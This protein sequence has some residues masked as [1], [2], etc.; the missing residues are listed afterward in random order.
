MFR[1]CSELEIYQALEK[2]EMD[3]DGAMRRLSNQGSFTH[4]R[5][6]LFL[7][8]ET[9]LWVF[10]IDSCEQRERDMGKRKKKKR[11]MAEVLMEPME[12]VEKF[13]IAPSN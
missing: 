7:L 9:S 3:F 6:S 8:L 10:L 13:L 2:C 5:H 4:F 11:E 1:H 12:K